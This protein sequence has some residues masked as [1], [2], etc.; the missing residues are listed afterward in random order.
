MHKEL[1]LL[2]PYR[3]AINRLGTNG[4]C[5][6][7]NGHTRTFL[8]HFTTATHRRRQTGST[9]VLHPLSPGYSGTR[10]SLFRRSS[11]EDSV[12]REMRNRYFDYI[13]RLVRSRCQG[14]DES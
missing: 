6:A 12:T 13:D 3:A 1:D 14:K 11:G 2:T 4:D 8:R 5:A 10:P 9:G 7:L